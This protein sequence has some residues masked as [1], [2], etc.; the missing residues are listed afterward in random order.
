[1]GKAAKLITFGT[2]IVFGS[3][4]VVL[5]YVPAEEPVPVEP[6]ETAVEQDESAGRAKGDQAKID[7]V[8]KIL[9]GDFTETF[10]SEFASN[11]GIA[12]FDRAEIMPG[13]N[14]ANVYSTVASTDKDD[15]RQTV[16]NKLGAMTVNHY[17]SDFRDRIDLNDVRIYGSD[18][19]D[20]G[21][22]FSDLRLSTDQK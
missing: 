17:Y 10:R 5:F 16:V 6:E 20:L 19:K 1:M 18:G 22:T 14:S 8:D 21:Y 15:V 9:S 4:V 13:K 7:K 12:L 11:D 2:L 3:L